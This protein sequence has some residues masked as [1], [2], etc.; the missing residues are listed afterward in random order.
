[1]SGFV[2]TVFANERQAATRFAESRQ[3]RCRG[4][5]SPSYSVRSAR[6]GS[7]EAARR[8]ILGGWQLSGVT[9][10]QTGLPFTPILSFDPTNSGTTAS[11]PWQ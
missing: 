3:W 11:S 6:A 8:A 9:S 7:V 1:M 4:A 2:K 10:H 5:R